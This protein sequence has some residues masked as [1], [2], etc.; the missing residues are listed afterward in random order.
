M[1]HVAVWKVLEGMIAD[2]RKKGM[3][4]PPQIMSDLK[5]AKTTIRILDV[6]PNCGESLQKIDQFLMNV[7]SY[8]V[9]EGQKKFGFEYIDPWLN[10]LEKASKETGDQEEKETRFVP[11]LPREQKWIRVAPSVDMSIEKLKTIADKMKLS[12]KAQKDG[13]LLVCGEDQNIKDFVKNMASKYKAKA[14]K[15]RKKVHNG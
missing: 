9:S 13:S 3:T 6:E 14:E 1:G 15:Y 11:G 7:E 10:R 12:Y 8:L 5:S 2:F 4:V